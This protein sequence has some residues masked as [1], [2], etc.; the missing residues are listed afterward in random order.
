MS[1]AKFTP[2]PWEFTVSRNGVRQISSKIKSQICRMWNCR[3][4]EGNAHLIAAAPEMYEALEGAAATLNFLSDHL[5][6]RMGDGALDD[7]RQKADSCFELLAKARG[8]A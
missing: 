5:R 7:M 8:E 4:T 6:G 3:E 1:K 2:G